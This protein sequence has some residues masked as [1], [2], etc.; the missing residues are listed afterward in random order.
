MAIEYT[1]RV[2]KLKKHPTYTDS[3]NITR[4]DVVKAALW[5]VTATTG[6]FSSS[7]QGTV[8]FNL[9]DLSN[10]TEFENL[11][12]PTVTEWVKEILSAPTSG[13]L[14]DWEE[15]VRDDVNYKISSSLNASF[16]F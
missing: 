2:A 1:W 10:Y 8:G 9:T 7:F 6:S 4:N 5:E 11:D 3:S 14:S 12:N 15:I 16:D 13:S